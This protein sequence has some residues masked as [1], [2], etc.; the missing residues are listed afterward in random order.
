[1]RRGLDALGECLQR[2][3]AADG[4]AE[5]ARVGGGLEADEVGGEDAFEEFLAD[6]EAAEDLG[7]G[8]GDVHEEADGCGGEA[9]ADEGGEEHEVVVVH[10]D[11]L[12][13][14]SVFYEERGMARDGTY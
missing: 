12:S 10:P 11:W 2:E 14:V 8:E 9:L 4:L 1:V 6:G 13:R 5:V 7:G 3:Y